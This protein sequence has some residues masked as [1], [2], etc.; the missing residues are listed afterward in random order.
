[1][2]Q[3]RKGM[4]SQN[5]VLQLSRCTLAPLRHYAVALLHHYAITPLRHCTVAPLRLFFHATL[6][7]TNMSYLY[8]LPKILFT[9][10]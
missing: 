9:L 4:K 8:N 1:M 7:C 2:A 10:R 3:G 5:I 6:S